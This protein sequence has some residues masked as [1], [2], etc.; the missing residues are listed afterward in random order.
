M[1]TGPFI[2][3]SLYKSKSA[4]KSQ[5]LVTGRDAH[6]A[7]GEFLLR[8]SGWGLRPALRATGRHFRWPF[9]PCT[10]RVGPS[11]LRRVC[12]LRLRLRSHHPPNC[13]LSWWWC[14]HATHRRFAPL[15]PGVSSIV[16][17]RHPP[18][19]RS[20]GWLAHTTDGFLTRAT[21]FARRAPCF[22]SEKPPYGPFG[23]GAFPS[24]NKAR[25]GFT[26][27]LCL[28]LRPCFLLKSSYF[29]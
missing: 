6:S 1:K 19:L 7:R 13:F 16:C 28:R 12:S 23:A 22:P 9:G 27:D 18:S 3:K 29:C 2:D 4:Y 10:L 20:S 14:S 15:G 21:R 5:I 8:P 26:H 24:E 25:L 17:A 11:G